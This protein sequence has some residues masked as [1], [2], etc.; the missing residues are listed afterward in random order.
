MPGACDPATGEATVIVTERRDSASHLLL[1]QMLDRFPAER[2]LVIEDNLSTHASRDGNRAL[3]SWPAIQVQVLPRY[4]SGMNLIEPWWQ[5]HKR[6]AL[7]GRRFE[8]ADE[9]HEAVEQAVAYVNAHRRPY[10]AEGP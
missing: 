4:A 7:K 2:W 9:I 5:P 8:I 1:E 6:L 10:G 3:L